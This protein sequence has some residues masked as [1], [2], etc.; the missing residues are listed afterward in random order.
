MWQ[1]C[2]TEFG[3]KKGMHG[4]LPSLERI[5]SGVRRKPKRHSG[6]S[7]QTLPSAWKASSAPSD[8]VTQAK[9][10]KECGYTHIFN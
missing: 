10:I 7:P 1:V 5:D 9:G 6:L 4:K 3:F 8:A 2:A